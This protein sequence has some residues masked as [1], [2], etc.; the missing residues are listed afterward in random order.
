MKTDEYLYTLFKEF[1]EQ[2]E[3]PYYFYTHDKDGNITYI[4]ENI[5][6]LLGLSSD[7]FKADYMSYATASPLNKEMIRYTYRALQGKEQ[8]AYKIE[9][10]DKDFHPHT[11]LIKE[12]PVFEGEKVVGIQGV[13]KLLS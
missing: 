9:I 4:S 7:E 13:A 12:K 6:H 8:E 5:T 10:Y 3:H 11:L 2:D 1:I